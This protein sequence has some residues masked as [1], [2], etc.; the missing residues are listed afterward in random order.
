[1]FMMPLV[2]PSPHPGPPSQAGR[3]KESRPPLVRL[4]WRV[5]SAFLILDVVLTSAVIAT[6]VSFASG[7]PPAASPEATAVRAVLD[8]QVAAWNRG[9]LDEFM[10]GYWKSDKLTFYSGDT[11]AQGWQATIYRYRKR[12]QSEGREMGKLEF[13]DLSVEILGGD[14]AVVRGRWHLTMKD[15]KTP[16]GLFT[17]LM[18]RIDG[19]WRIVHDHTSAAETK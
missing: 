15:G 12:Y 5:V 14:A 6:I 4:S 13:R 11:I 19:D 1:M 2:P 7:A 9:D 17:L 18:R 8:A 16:N 10:I 3:E